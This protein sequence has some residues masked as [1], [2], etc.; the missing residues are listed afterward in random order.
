MGDITK[1]AV[2]FHS[3]GNIAEAENFYLEVLKKDPNN[4]N[5]LY[6]LGLVYYEKRDYKNEIKVLERAAQLSDSDYEIYFMLGLAYKNIFEFE[7]AERAYLRAIALEPE[8]SKTY[9]N[10]AIVYLS[11]NQPEKAIENFKICID[12]NPDDIEAKYFLGLAYFRCKEYKK[13]EKFFDSRLCRDTAIKTQFAVYPNIMQR[14]KLWQ[15]EDI[16]DKTLYTYYEAGFGDMI[17]FAR[18]LPELRKRCKRLIVK[19]QRE[20]YQLF[21]DNFPDIE[22]MDFFSEEKFTCF[23]YH[24]P[25]LSIPSVLDFNDEKTFIGHEGYLKATKEKIEYFKNKYFDNDKFKIA[26]K[27]QGNTYYETDRVIDVDAFAPLFDIPNAKIYS[28][29]TFEGLEN[30]KILSD[31]YD[32]TD[33]S[34]DF[35]DFSYTAGALANVDLVISSDSSLA[36]VAGAMGIPCIIL[37]PYNYN[38]RW[39]M[40]LS[41][42][43]WYDSVK[44]YRLGKTQTWSELI[45]E[46][47]K[48]YFN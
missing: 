9:Y 7:K 41:K 21:K 45:K 10:L 3:S 5:V 15:G 42:C 33:L 25:F 12:K 35:K 31:K 27:W 2:N 17:M 22:F 40:D 38:W 28:A 23:D 11:L 4:I 1:K 32:I 34:S 26:I 47:T 13:G 44:L 19:P 39:H 6:N 18:Y 36:H 48:Q 30:L 24:I 29:Q 16:S 8:N 43:D 14:A 20:L 37:L 46:I